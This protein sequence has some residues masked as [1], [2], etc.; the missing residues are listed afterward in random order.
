MQ[1]H[2][3]KMSILKFCPAWMLPL[4]FNLPLHDKSEDMCSLFRKIP[5]IRLVFSPYKCHMQ[6]LLAAANREKVPVKF[7][8]V[9]PS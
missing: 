2:L 5:F 4:I 8:S 6:V 1:V 7:T 3:E 9:F